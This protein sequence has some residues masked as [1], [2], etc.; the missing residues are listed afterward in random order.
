MSLILVAIMATYSTGRIPHA[1]LAAMTVACSIAIAMPRPASAIPYFAHENGMS[2]Q[3]CHSVV[4]R[5]NDFGEAFEEHGFAIPGARPTH[6]VPLAVKINSAYTSEADA[7]GLPKATLDEVEIFLAG[8]IAS[9]ANYFVEQY[10][11]DGARPGV[12]RDAWLRYRATP[13]DAAVPVSLRAGSFTLPLPVDPESMRE[14][15]S[16]YALFDQ[17]V[18]DN[19]F[20]F[21]DAKIGGEVRVGALER[22]TSVAALALGG[23]DVQSG[24]AAHGIDTMLSA[25]HVVGAVTVSAYRYAGARPIAGELDRFWRLG[26]GVAYRRGAFEAQGVVQ[27]GADGRVD[28]TG[29]AAMSSGGFAQVRYAFTRKLF[30][31]VRYEGTNDPSHGFVRDVVPLLGYRLTRNSRLTIED[32]VTHVPTAKHTLGT[33]YTVS[34]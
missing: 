11:I 27:T 15:L 5:L 14:S 4:P 13:D 19:P 23:H 1:R 24:I 22:G 21:F 28:E 25:Q 2:C 32:V 30:G 12:T 16:H 29:A 8:R 33:Q 31:L 3:K 9:R 20:A 17:R 7:T 26:Y 6:A 18:G 34:Y 10:A